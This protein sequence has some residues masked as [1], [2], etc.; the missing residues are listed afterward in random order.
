MERILV[1]EDDPD[2][3]LMLV[4]LLE[5]E[6]FEAQG[7][8]SGPEAVQALDRGAFDLVV[9]DLMLGETSGYD[10]LRQME[11][12]GNREHVKVLMLT[13]RASETDILDGW[14]HRVDEF[15]TKPFDVS[16]LVEAIRGTLN[17]TP[18]ELSRWREGQLRRAELFTNL[19][20][21]FEGGAST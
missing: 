6:G 19:E 1:V 8:T 15:R 13:A 10:V 12:Q 3:R 7:V 20:T 2:V 14:R 11:Q 21:V 9:L 18:E 5:L 4:R 17:R 16:D